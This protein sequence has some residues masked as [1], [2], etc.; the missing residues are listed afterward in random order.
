MSPTA[1]LSL[2]ESVAREVLAEKANP[3]AVMD[4][5]LDAL[6]KNGSLNKINAT[7]HKKLE[8]AFRKY[9]AAAL[10]KGNVQ[11]QQDDDFRTG[12]EIG[13]AVKQGAQSART[14]AGRLASAGAEDVRTAAAR[15]AA[16]IPG[17]MG[18]ELGA[19]YSASRDVNV[20]PKT[21]FWI[22]VAL[23]NLVAGN[24]GLPDY[25]SGLV[26]DV[27]AAPAEAIPLVGG[28]LAD[29]VRATL[30]PF[31]GLDDAALLMWAKRKAKKA[32][33]PAAKHY[34]EFEKWGKFPEGSMTPQKAKQLA[35]PSPSASHN[36]FQATTK[37]MGRRREESI[38]KKSELMKIIREEV[39][40]ILTNA[41]AVEM[42]DLDPDMLQEMA[43]TEAPEGKG[44]AE[45]EGGSGCI[46]KKGDQWVIMN[47]KKGG[48]FRKCDSEAHCE[49][50]LD[51]FHAAKG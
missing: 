17:G 10:K 16:A 50:I 22:T 44:C 34:A 46:K 25:I 6:V 35:D 28:I 24:F 20:D 5:T 12:R 3:S 14:A 23:I 45:S 39:E 51:A 19:L 40:V 21:R 47:N 38:M 7:L 9:I 36:M 8:P 2:I 18:T 27:I 43:L 32:N 13:T 26:L 4:Q 30:S 49:E 42:F 11:E 31:Q 33:L 48:I 41:E 15:L 37:G 29:I 1:T